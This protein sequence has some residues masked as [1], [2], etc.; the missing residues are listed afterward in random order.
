MR[1]KRGWYGE[2]YRH[3]LARHGVKSSQQSRYNADNLTFTRSVVKAFEDKMETAGAKE[4][5]RE[6]ARVA[7]VGQQEA[8]A[9]PPS[10]SGGEEAEAQVRAAQILPAKTARERLKILDEQSQYLN[11]VRAQLLR[12]DLQLTQGQKDDLTRRLDVLNQFAGKLYE[13]EKEKSDYSKYYGGDQKK[14]QRL[15]EALDAATG[16][17]V[18]TPNTA[19]EERMEKWAKDAAASL[20]A[21]RRAFELKQETEELSK[22]ASNARLVPYGWVTKEKRRIEVP[23]WKDTSALLPIEREVQTKAG[24]EA[25]RV[26][27]EWQRPPR[28]T[29]VKME[30]AQRQKYGIDWA[31]PEQ[32]S[33]FRRG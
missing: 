26:K 13:E 6:A 20:M 1:M 31:T 21:A 19:E 15:K 12:A 30:P 24:A 14:Q 7:A 22:T 8:L 28:L 17:G 10:L 27:Y 9:A 16:E 3:Y 23:I 32:K 4:K 33:K 2:S 5:M 11:P 25:P 18:F 29:V